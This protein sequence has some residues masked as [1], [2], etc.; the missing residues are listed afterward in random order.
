MDSSITYRIQQ[1]L[2]AKLEILHELLQYLNDQLAPQ[3]GAN[4]KKHK[5]VNTRV[6]N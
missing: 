1:T 4:L 3:C 5:I 6:H 2:S